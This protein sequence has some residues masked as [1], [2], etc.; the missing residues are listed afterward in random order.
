[1]TVQPR[2]SRGRK[3]PAEGSGAAPAKRMPKAQRRSR[4]LEAA[5]EIVQS[6]GTDGLTLARVAE[7]AGVTK[8]IAYEHFGTRAGLLM[9]LYRHYDEQQTL[10]MRAALEA[11]GRTLEDVA[12]ILSA[13][14]IDCGVLAGPELGAITAALSATEEMEG[15][16]QSCRLSFMAECRAAFAP[17]IDLRD[18]QDQAIDVAIIGAA[19]ALS[20]AAA[21][22]R[23]SRDEAVAMLAR[24]M[25]GTL[26]QTADGPSRASPP[27]QL[28]DP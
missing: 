15:L 5:H 24:I 9:A 3:L 7:R 18:G 22:G 20:N 27:A 12:S 26:R 17:F 13:A 25:A 4:L 1:M 10:A 14:Y 8:P 19:E 11:G 16:L 2:S 6:E 21:A 28:D 23:V